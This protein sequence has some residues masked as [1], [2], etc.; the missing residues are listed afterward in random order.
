MKTTA[1]SAYRLFWMLG[2][3]TTVPVILISGPLAGYWIAEWLLVR[4]AGWPRFWVPVGVFLGFIGAVLQIIRIIKQ[5]QQAESSPTTEH[6]G[7]S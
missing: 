6:K 3:A 1:G 2:A 5:I 7:V 4:H